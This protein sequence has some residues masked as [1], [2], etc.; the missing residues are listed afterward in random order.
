MLNFKF[1]YAIL[2]ILVCIFSVG[3]KKVINV[4]LKNTDPQIVITGEVN[5]LIGPYKVTIT[6]SVNYTSNNTFPAVSGAFVTISDKTIIDTLKETSPG[7]YTSNNIKGM[8]GNA[9]S[10]YVIAEGQTFTATSIMPQQVVFDSV[11][12]TSGFKNQSDQT[13]NTVAYFKDPAGIANYYEF[14]AYKN[15]IQF[16]NNG[17]F[18]LFDDRLSDGKFIDFTIDNDYKSGDEFVVKMSCIDKNVYS[19]L[20]TLSAISADSGRVNLQS[21][22][23]ANPISNISNNALG[24][25]S[26]QFVQSKK[27]VFP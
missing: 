17:G 26:A 2:P 27:Q 6:K 15:G 16:K 12:F 19:Y 3:C 5:N 11:G 20:N 4:N 8:P 10:L 25:F 23:P 22:A 18:Q 21:P 9:Y 13:Y 14:S 1:N 7:V 24:Y